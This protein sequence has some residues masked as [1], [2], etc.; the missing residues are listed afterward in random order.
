MAAAQVNVDQ[1]SGVWTAAKVHTFSERN[2]SSKC[3]SKNEKR[4][5]KSYF[6]SLIL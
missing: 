4:A 3:W 2:V 5:A 6:K 1:Q